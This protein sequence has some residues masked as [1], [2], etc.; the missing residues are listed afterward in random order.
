MIGLD[1]IASERLCLTLLHS[2]WQ[3]ALLAFAAWGIGRCLGRHRENAS[4]VVHATALVLGL[5]AAPITHAFLSYGGS[6]SVAES[7]PP[8]VAAASVSADIDPGVSQLPPELATAAEAQPPS[9]PTS[10]ITQAA[11]VVGAVPGFAWQSI[12]PWLAGAYLFGVVLMLARLARSAF[13]L[14]RLRATAQPVVDGPVFDALA[15]ICSQWSLKT[16][17]VL[18]HAEQ[19]VVPK[20]V[21]FLK[22]TILLPSSALIGLPIDDLELILAH[23]LAHVRRHDLWINLL[24]RLAEAILFFNPAMWWLSRRVSTLREYCCD[25]RACAVIPEGAKPQLRYAEAL[26]HA[27]ELQHTGS[28]EQVAALAATGRSPSELRRRVARLFGEP[29]GE[30]IRLSRGGIVV[31]LAGL[32][33]LFIV[34]TLAGSAPESADE[35]TDRS[36]AETRDA[37][38]AQV[39]GNIVLEDGA[40]SAVAGWLYSEGSYQASE[41][42]THSWTSTE[43]RFTESFQCDLNPGTVWLK[44]FPRDGYAPAAVGPFELEAGETL[45]EVRIELTPGH[46]QSVSVV[47]DGY[48]PIEG[49]TVVAHPLLGGSTDGPVHPQTTDANGRVRLEHV[50]PD[51]RYVFRVEAPGF[52]KLRTEPRRLPRGGEEPLS[53]W[54][55]RAQP[56]TG[57]VRFPDG[58]PAPATKLKELVELLPTG[59]TNS[60]S[61]PRVL[62]TTD[63]RGRFKLDSLNDD[64]KYAVVVESP[65]L[66]RAVTTVVKAGTQGAQIVLPERHDLV[67]RVKGDLQGV[68]KRE[69]KPCVKIYQRFD[70]TRD[71]RSVETLLTDYATLE[72]TAEGGQAIHRGLAIDLRPD[73][74]TQRVEV[75]LGQDDSTKQVVDIARNSDR[76]T[77]VEFDLRPQGDAGSQLESKVDRVVAEARARTFG[78]Q[79]VPR[80]LIRMTRRGGEIPSMRAVASGELD[81]LWKARGQATE[82][83][84]GV[85]NFV[86]WD[87]ERLLIEDRYPVTESRKQESAQSRYWDGREGWIG[88]TYASP[89]NVY[90]YSTIEKLTDFLHPGMFP[91]WHAAGGRLAWPGPEVVLRENETAPGQTR[92]LPAGEDTVDGVACRVFDGPERMEKIWVEK[93]S[94]LIKAV[95]QYYAQNTA[96]NLEAERLKQ[97]TGR[98]FAGVGEYR[99]WFDEQTEETKAELRVYWAQQNWKDAYPGNLSIF[100]EYEEISPGKRW[101]MRCERIVCHA[102]DAKRDRFKFYLN[103]VV[104]TGV[105]KDFIIEELAATALPEPGVKVTDRTTTVAFDYN[106]DEAL[107]EEQIERFREAKLA[108]KRAEEAEENRINATPID[109]VADAIEILTEGPATDPTKVWARAIKHLA[110]HPAPALPALIEK[111]DSEDRDHPISKL[112]FALRAIGDARAVPALIRALPRTLQPSRSDYGL[113]LEDR[114]LCRFMQEHDD[115]KSGGNYFSYHRA[116]REVV[117]SLRRL[118]GKQFNEMELNWIHLQE[119]EP[120]RRLARQQFDRV[121]Q[122]WAAWWEANWQDHIEDP[123]YARVDLPKT[124]APAGR[125]PAAGKPPSGP[126]VKLVGINSGTFQSVHNG[127]GSCFV[128]LDTRREAGW[129]SELPP[130][131]KTL[132]DSPE[133]RDWARRE[134]FDLVGITYTPEG[135]QEPLCCVMPL[136]LRAWAITEEE[137]RGLPDMLRG[138]KPYPFTRPVDLL[139][140]RREIPKPR[141][142]EHS[143]DSFLFVT[144]EGTAGVLRLTAQVTEGTDISGYA[145]SVDDQ[146]E[147]VGFYRGVKYGLHTMSKPAVAEAVRNTKAVSANPPNKADTDLR[148]MRIR[149]LDELENPLGGAKLYVNAL[150]P[151]SYRGKRSANQD[152]VADSAGSVVLSIPRHLII[153]RLWP[154]KDGYVSEFMNYDLGLHREGELIPDELVF[155]LAKGSKIAE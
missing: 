59:Y 96:W 155:R 151:S 103:E 41:H 44:F 80:I 144:R 52:Q 34:P 95:S 78:L 82:K 28:S 29:I 64:S 83:L 10:P 61:S 51:T 31:L 117:C 19:V 131:G 32:A 14:E 11:P 18:A 70:V 100:S 50:A 152:L 6:T 58:S 119:T 54:M 85:H 98:A 4:Y 46:E 56:A 124:V 128:D 25:D 36:P 134:G 48:Q 111:L 22:P 89:K 42:A 127:S 143:G 142:P 153:L 71:D 139:V 138:K 94:G 101:P 23:E 12:M 2:L 3:V 105:E 154:Q 84:P 141:D 150:R 17:P 129:P 149:I 24:Q 106:W 133:L 113:T 66:S 72:P 7:A 148:E 37:K 63:G 55:I 45:K 118:T 146:F 75:M 125:P 68:T 115:G 126:G 73:A 135:E 9:L 67:V 27:V 30:S 15:S 110:D 147:G 47:T 38:R 13:L 77:F 91:Q 60:F 81:Q 90:R 26:L 114:E 132:L 69:G 65:D 88:E 120:Q 57:V 86:A 5:I 62:A 121:A 97:I 130:L 108:E 43:G 79:K 33:I 87:G 104:T 112:A 74:G 39:T 123:A 102:L 136:D 21:G 92:Y 137:H 20:V 16:A 76:A 8:P 93:E 99:Q 107:S 140:P 116:F 145:S 1:S 122:K 109:S 35:S 53:L 49:A 40:P